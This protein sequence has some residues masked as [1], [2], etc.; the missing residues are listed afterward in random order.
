[1]NRLA[2]FLVIIFFSK[3]NAFGQKAN[4]TI[5]ADFYNKTIECTLRDSSFAKIF[6]AE[7]QKYGTIYTRVGI[8]TK[9]LIKKTDSFRVNYF[10]NLKEF[11]KILNKYKGKSV[12]M[13]YLSLYYDTTKNDT[14]D[15]F[16]YVGSLTLSRGLSFHRGRIRFKNY[17]IGYEPIN[18]PLRNN[19]EVPKA[20]VILNNGEWSYHDCND[21]L[22]LFQKR[23]W[24]YGKIKSEVIK[25]NFDTCR[26]PENVE[27]INNWLEKN[28][29][30]PKEC[31]FDGIEGDLII[32]F[33]IDENGKINTYNI[34]QGLRKDL[35]D[36]LLKSLE[37]I[38]KYWGK[39]RCNNIYG[40]QYK[41]IFLIKYRIK[42]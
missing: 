19:V 18:D 32:E 5:L 40:E 26:I 35:N 27:K 13:R 1:M 11:H 21:I 34:I 33:T 41:L 22:L 31:I 8:D 10:T 42:I 30:Y 4:D 24:G 25:N 17:L 20:R 15:I 3:M 36:E 28:I 12:S 7:Q 14:L 38:P 39:R 9:F 23:Y 37:R 29:V 16:A 6:N 2:F